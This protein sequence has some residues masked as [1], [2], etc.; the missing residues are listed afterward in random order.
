MNDTPP[1]TETTDALPED[2]AQESASRV[3]AMLD[4]ARTAY[5]KARQE[6]TEA[7]ERLR[8]EL[9]N[10]DARK[11]G[12]NAREWV[13][14]NPGLSLLLAAGAG[15][16][17]GKTLANALRE[18]PLTWQDRARMRAGRLSNEARRFADEASQRVSRQLSDSGDEVSN[19]IRSLGSRMQ[20]QAG[21][22]SSTLAQHAGELSV[23]GL[24]RAQHWLASL[25][26][27]AEQ[28]TRSLQKATREAASA[29]GQHVPDRQSLRDGVN[30]AVQ[31]L[32]GVIA[33]KKI[34]DWIKERY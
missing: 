7:T 9:K 30:R 1:K 2:G 24:R 33:F 11:A 6:M 3:D 29:A 13:R 20:H 5:E 10:F 15:L 19:H 22:L 28:A 12:E 21:E 32:F 26:D 27:S 17:L 4:E 34:S 25:T 18:E 31:T 23:E 8:G 16:V 14:E